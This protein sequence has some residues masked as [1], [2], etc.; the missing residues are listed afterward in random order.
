MN[1]LVYSIYKYYM[2]YVQPMKSVA[3]GLVPALNANRLPSRAPEHAIYAG[4][5]DYGIF[6]K[7]RSYNA[8]NQFLVRIVAAHRQVAAGSPGSSDPGSGQEEWSLDHSLPGM[9]PNDKQV[10]RL[11]RTVNCS[12][13]ICQPG[14]AAKASDMTKRKEN[15]ARK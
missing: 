11:Q 8:E 14:T 7:G 6:D 9:P 1:K 2:F 4:S 10:M 15:H 13:T 12:P 3:A 5:R